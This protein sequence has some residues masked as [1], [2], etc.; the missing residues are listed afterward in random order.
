M[1]RTGCAMTVSDERLGLPN[2]IEYDVSCSNVLP[3]R[4]KVCFK[5]AENGIM[6]MKVSKKITA[7]SKQVVGPPV[8]GALAL[9]VKHDIATPPQPFIINSCTHT[10]GRGGGDGVNQRAELDKWLKENCPYPNTNRVTQLFDCDPRDLSTAERSDIIRRT[11]E[12]VLE[13]RRRSEKQKKVRAARSSQ[14]T[15]RLPLHQ[16][17]DKYI[18]SGEP[19]YTGS[20]HHY[21]NQ[22]IAR[23]LVKA[24]IQNYD[25]S[26]EDWQQVDKLQAWDNQRL[27]EWLKA[28]STDNRSYDVTGVHWQERYDPQP[29]SINDSEYGGDSIPWDVYPPENLDLNTSDKRSDLKISIAKLDGKLETILET[30]AYNQ[31]M[32][33]QRLQSTDARMKELTQEVVW[34]RESVNASF[35]EQ[36][37]NRKVVATQYKHLVDK[38]DWVDEKVGGMGWQVSKLTSVTDHLR[39]IQDE[40]FS[41]YDQ[42]VQQ[43]T[44]DYKEQESHLE[45]IRTD[46]YSTDSQINALKMVHDLKDNVDRDLRNIRNVSNSRMEEIRDAASPYQP[47]ST[48][49]TPRAR[50]RVTK[51]VIDERLERLVYGGSWVKA[52]IKKHR[53]NG[54][55]NSNTEL[56]WSPT[57]VAGEGLEQYLRKEREIINNCKTVIPDPVEQRDTVVGWIKDGWDYSVYKAYRNKLKYTENNSMSAFDKMFERAKIGAEKQRLYRWHNCNYNRTIQNNEVKLYFNQE[58]H[59][60]DNWL[61]ERSCCSYRNE[62]SNYESWFVIAERNKPSVVRSPHWCEIGS[63]EKRKIDFIMNSTWDLEACVNRQIIHGPPLPNHMMLSPNGLIVPKKDIPLIAYGDEI[64]QDADIVQRGMEVGVPYLSLLNAGVDLYNSSRVSLLMPGST[65]P[66]NKK[67]DKVVNSKPS[68]QPTVVKPV[69]QP[70]VSRI[71]DVFKEISKSFKQIQMV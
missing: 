28:M 10:K 3:M 16:G 49:V 38:I 67:V 5:S 54:Y 48:L 9:A 60:L 63:D 30:L 41:T 22:V 14:P 2:P 37:H 71:N 35:T 27:Q 70:I 42:D 1:M 39:E 34:M 17:G 52:P 51:K 65:D 61:K 26:W 31:G 55:G 45:A 8:M 40:I 43:A 21:P 13:R 47:V 11:K 23:L 7:S 6:A 59:R 62:T 46:V 69:T 4:G 36:A 50:V 64:K 66:T 15:V 20:V 33:E 68:T 24:R 44:A 32:I 29:N 56:V 18:T 19:L 53:D 25:P 12:K 58:R 57:Y